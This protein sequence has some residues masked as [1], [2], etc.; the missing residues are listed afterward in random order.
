VKICRSMGKQFCGKITNS[1]SGLLAIFFDKLLTFVIAESDYNL[2]RMM[3]LQ[4]KCTTPL[5]VNPKNL[6]H[7]YTSFHLL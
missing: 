5:L 1:A 2:V 6:N 4:K 3:I 7:A